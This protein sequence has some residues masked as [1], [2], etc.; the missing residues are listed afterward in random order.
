MFVKDES[1]WQK[2]VTIDFGWYSK[3]KKKA[4][5]KLNTKLCNVKHRNNTHK[6]GA[7][8]NL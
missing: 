2:F 8:Q 4:I 7:N 1:H 6:Y 3:W 5:E